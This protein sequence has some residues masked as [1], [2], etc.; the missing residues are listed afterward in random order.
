MGDLLRR[1]KSTRPTLSGITLLEARAA[2]AAR[3]YAEAELRLVRARNEA[4]ADVAE[5]AFLRA[6]NFGL[7]RRFDDMRASLD[8]A[9]AADPTRAEFH[10][11]RAEID[12]R[13]GRPQD[14]LESYARALER[15][16]SGRNPSTDTIAFRRRL[17]LIENGRESEID[18][19]EFETL[20]AMSSPPG[21]WLLTAAAV[22]LQRRDAAEAAR[23]LQRARTA[24]P[25][26]QYLERLDDYFF[27][28]HANRPELKGLFPSRLERARFHETSRPSFIDP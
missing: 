22:A 16:R 26:V 19:R 11:T 1:L 5:I 27:R 9:I 28:N 14:A 7:Q 21:D 6:S 2:T 18:A 25:W 24:M 8:D 3:S 15:S 12:R 4:T 20:L 17:L 13:L 23:W 10:F